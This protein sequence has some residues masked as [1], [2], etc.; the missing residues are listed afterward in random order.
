MAALVTSPTLS[1]CTYICHHMRDVDRAEVYGMSPEQNWYKL[2]ALVWTMMRDHGRGVVAW[3]DGKPA[4]LCGFVERWP[5]M[6]EI[7]MFGTDDL[8]K[9]A[10]PLM[11]WARRQIPDII[12]NHG[13]RRL[14]CDSRVGHD[15]AHKMLQALGAVKEG[16]PM[17]EYGT[18]GSAYQRF[19][20]IA[21]VNDSIAM[22]TANDVL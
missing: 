4:A 12:E 20:W 2:G 9:V 14:Q 3:H 17:P 1:A 16:A 18:D 19:V 15:E 21:G 7:M 10:I 11:Q 6:W 5:G 22:R 8:T 13:G